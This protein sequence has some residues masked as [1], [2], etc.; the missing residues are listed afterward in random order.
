MLNEAWQNLSKVP[1]IL[2]ALTKIF[3]S[4]AI[5]QSIERHTCLASININQHLLKSKTN[6]GLALMPLRDA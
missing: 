4:A 6:F 3:G 2:G 5:L 1:T